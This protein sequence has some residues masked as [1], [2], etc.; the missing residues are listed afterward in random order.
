M[1]GS[2]PLFEFHLNCYL[3]RVNVPTITFVVE[4]PFPLAAPSTVPSPP[5]PTHGLSHYSPLLS[6]EHLLVSDNTLWHVVIVN[7]L[8]VDS[9]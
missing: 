9:N 3:L 4:P 8:T 5:A 7:S 6:L 2:F 1:C